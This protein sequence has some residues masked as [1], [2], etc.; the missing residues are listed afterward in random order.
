MLTKLLVLFERLVLAMEK[1]AVSMAACPVYPDN[2]GV[3]VP[4]KAALVSG[5]QTFK[6][7]TTVETQPET[8]PPAEDDPREKLKKE[9]TARGITF[10]ASART[11]TLQKMLAEA[12]ARE[13]TP[14]NPQADVAAAF[15]TD[16]PAKGEDPFAIVPPAA[17][18]VEVTKKMVQDHLVA[19]SMQKSKEEAINMLKTVGKAERLSD[20]DASLYAALVQGCKAAGIEVA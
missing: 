16:P 9:L 12:I 6:Y 4:E 10:K 17:P 15:T 11:E 20:V 18:P 8:T 19:L 2:L 14:K 13:N 3:T 5:A 7:A 1:I